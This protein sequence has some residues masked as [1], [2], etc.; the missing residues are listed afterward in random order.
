M[1]SKFMST[2]EVEGILA[3]EKEKVMDHSFYTA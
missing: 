2:I 1:T 3:D